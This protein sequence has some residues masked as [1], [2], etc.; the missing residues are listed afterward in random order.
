MRRP[1]GGAH[2]SLCGCQEQYTEDFDT[3]SFLAALPSKPYRGTSLIRKRHPPRNIVGPWAYAYCKV[4]GER[5][6]L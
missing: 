2:T 3:S 1:K 6:F 4:L 5:V